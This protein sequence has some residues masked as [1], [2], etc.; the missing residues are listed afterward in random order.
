LKLLIDTHILLWWLDNNPLLSR[1][2][3]G[4]IANPENSVFVSAVSVWEIR[5]KQSLGRL[6]LPV[7]FEARLAKEL[8]ES[9]PLTARQTGPIVEMPWHHRDPFDRILVAQA[10][11]EGMF[12][13]TADAGLAAHGEFVRVLG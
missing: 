12:F 6:S 3:R 10:Q 7:D 4:L 8:F 9:L 11:A 13:L 2:A 1:A 5:L